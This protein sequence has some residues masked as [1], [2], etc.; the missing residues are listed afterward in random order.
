MLTT[1]PKKVD[2][3]D[4]IIPPKEEPKVIDKKLDTNGIEE[5]LNVI[6]KTLTDLVNKDKTDYS[7]V[8]LYIK[9]TLLS[10]KDSNN[11]LTNILERTEKQNK[12]LLDQLVKLSKVKQVELP[13][14]LTKV[15]DNNTKAIEKVGKRYKKWEFIFDR[16]NTGIYG[17]TAKAIE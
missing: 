17:A 8:F 14:D 6:N 11:N 4:D 10:L 12:L 1:R 5:C 3:V 16:D 7:N 15:I 13:S 9:E 2:K